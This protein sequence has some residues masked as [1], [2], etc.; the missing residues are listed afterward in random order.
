MVP[1]NT[2]LA[3]NFFRTGVHRL[4][5]SFRHESSS[6]K[7]SPSPS[8]LPLQSVV[9]IVANSSCFDHFTTAAASTNPCRHRTEMTN[10]I[11]D[12][13]SRQ[14]RR[15]HQN[16][17]EIN[18]GNH[19]SNHQSIDIQIDFRYLP[20]RNNPDLHG[21]RNPLLRPKT[22]RGT[23]AITRCRRA[24]QLEPGSGWHSASADP[25]RQECC[26]GVYILHDIM[27]DLALFAFLL[28][29]PPPRHP[30]CYLPRRGV[31]PRNQTNTKYQMETNSNS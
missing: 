21:S 12:V 23:V 28:L 1:I 30:L 26:R 13:V 15:H 10:S 6:W 22:A 11:V 9:A 16:R 14:S 5:T 31:R 7:S 4:T 17:N 20:S 2:I 3:H 18:S 24:R 29:V 8:P 19:P 27:D 25:S